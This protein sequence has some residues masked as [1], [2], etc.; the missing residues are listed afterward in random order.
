M[1]PMYFI[2]SFYRFFTVTDPNALGAKLESLAKGHKLLGSIIVAEEGLNASLEASSYQ[3]VSDF[4][5][6][7]EDLIGIRPLDY[8]QSTSDR[9]GFRKLL[10]KLKRHILTFNA[11]APSLDEIN[12]VPALSASD[13]D[14]LTSIEG[15]SAPILVDTRNDY[16]VARGTFHG[17]EHLEISE[18]AEFSEAFL[19]R[20]AGQED[21]TYIVFCTGGIRCEKAAPFLVSS[22]FTNVLKLDGGILKYL[23]KQGP[24]RWNGEVFVFDDR[25]TLGA[26]D[27][28]F[29]S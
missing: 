22:V 24:G 11:M 10:I 7:L 21:R 17:A 19:S 14:A 25:L 16:E 8:R 6:D 26:D 20:Y 2:F 27:V 9:P 13:F 5:Q 4:M 1:T 15:S 28:G 29:R 12:S 18:F 23:E 3:N